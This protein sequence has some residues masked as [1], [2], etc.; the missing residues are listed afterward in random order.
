MFNLAVLPPRKQFKGEIVTLMLIL[1]TYCVLCV[2]HYYVCHCDC[3]VPV[4]ITVCYLII[5][6]LFNLNN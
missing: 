1:T 5:V 4:V 3:R 6:C 2:R